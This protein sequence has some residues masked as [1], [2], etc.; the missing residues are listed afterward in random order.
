MDVVYEV[1]E[2]VFSAG[3]QAGVFADRGVQV[4]LV[5]EAQFELSGIT[6]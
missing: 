4:D 6:K 1:L 5:E 3:G 2:P